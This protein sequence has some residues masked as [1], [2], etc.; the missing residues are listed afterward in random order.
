[1]NG[2]IET[3]RV[4]V[5]EIIELLGLRPHPREGGYYR[6][7]YRSAVPFVS[8]EGPVTPPGIRSSATDIYYL[9]RAGSKSLLHRIKSDELWH[10]YLGGPI[11]IVELHPDGTVDEVVLGSS[12]RSGQ[13]L[14]HVVRAGTW[15][16]AYTEHDTGFALVGC[17]VVAP[18]FDFHDFEVGD[19]H[20][21]SALYPQAS[22]LVEKL[23]EPE[24]SLHP[25]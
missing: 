16:G 5:D 24:F 17:T 22:T 9:L 13:R 2:G 11:T 15:F 3:E 7:T 12:L 14:K 6:E 1:M 21:L 20:Q 23:T 18:G 25:P 4:E 10:F 8:A 19:R